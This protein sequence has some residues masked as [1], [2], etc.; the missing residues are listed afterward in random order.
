MIER[1][2]AAYE[3]KFKAMKM[4]ILYSIQFTPKNKSGRTSGCYGWILQMPSKV[5]SWYIYLYKQLPYKNL[6]INNNGLIEWMDIN[7]SLC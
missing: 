5:V 1:H 4:N 7:L 3:D 6:W 2:Q